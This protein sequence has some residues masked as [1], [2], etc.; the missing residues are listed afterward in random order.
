MN[1]SILKHIKQ[2]GQ[3]TDTEIAAALGLK[4]DA[5]HAA[6]NE[7]S[8]QGEIACCSV[9]RFPAGK[10]VNAILCRASG[11]APPPAPGRKPKS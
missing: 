4:L 6:L 8:L 1:P 3:V 10:P 11:Y 2:Q 9:T 7:L 5:V